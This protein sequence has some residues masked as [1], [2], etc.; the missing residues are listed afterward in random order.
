MILSIAATWLEQEK[1]D[2][3]A[4][5][6]AY[7]VESCPAPNLGGDQAALMVRILKIQKLMAKHKERFI[8]N[9]KL[10]HFLHTKL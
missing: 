9:K 10:G 2:L 1:K 4:A 6:E 3:V 5:K 8:F 7:M